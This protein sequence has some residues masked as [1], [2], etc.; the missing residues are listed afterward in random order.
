MDIESFSPSRLL[1]CPIGLHAVNRDHIVVIS[2]SRSGV[3]M[4][5]KEGRI[6][7]VV[8]PLGLGFRVPSDLACLRNRTTGDDKGC[9]VPVSKS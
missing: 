3:K 1:D 9:F 6:M 8:D 2:T 5:N 7:S 4:I